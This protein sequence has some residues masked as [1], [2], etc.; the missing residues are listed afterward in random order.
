VLGPQNCTPLYCGIEAF[1]TVAACLLDCLSAINYRL[2]EDLSRHSCVCANHRAGLVCLSGCDQ[3]RL[4]HSAQNESEWTVT[5][6]QKYLLNL[7]FV[8]RFVIKQINK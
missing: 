7:C 5:K 6:Y 4:R 2:I 8:H 1:L 3:A